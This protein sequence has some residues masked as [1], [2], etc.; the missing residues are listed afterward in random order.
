MADSF[1]SEEREGQSLLLHAVAEI[2]DNAIREGVGYDPEGLPRERCPMFI[3]KDERG[4]TF[5]PRILDPE[6]EFRIE[7]GRE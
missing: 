4:L 3:A 2:L 7:E 5:E 1:I 6:E